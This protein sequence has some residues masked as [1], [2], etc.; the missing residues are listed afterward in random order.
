MQKTLKFTVHQLI[1]LI[2]STKAVPPP[3]VNISPAPTVRIGSNVT[4]RCLSIFKI[5]PIYYT[6]YHMNESSH[7]Y[8]Q[9]GVGANLSLSN[10]KVE[11]SGQYNCSIATHLGENST[12]VEL[13]VVEILSNMSV[14]ATPNELFVFEGQTITLSCQ[15][16]TSRL[17]L[18]WSWYRQSPSGAS[19][20]GSG[21]ELRLDRVEDSGVYYCQANSTVMTITQIKQSPNYEAHIVSTPAQFTVG[22]ATLILVVLSWVVLILIIAWLWIQL[23]KERVN[24]PETHPSRKGD[25]LDFTITLNK[26]KNLEMSGDIYENYEVSGN[27]YT[28]LTLPRAQDEDMYDTLS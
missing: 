5:P 7:V 11:D 25:K 10:I 23:K 3:D 4:L 18:T 8:K 1:I 12:V 19:M 24:K 9:V 20:V 16:Q 2:L 22:L 27:N 17:N 28:D 13:T 26:N 6:W 21:R 15:S 14:L